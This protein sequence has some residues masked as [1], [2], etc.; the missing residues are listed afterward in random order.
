M[1]ISNKFNKTI[2]AGLLI[3]ATS[4]TSIACTTANFDNMKDNLR[5]TAED[6]ATGKITNIVDQGFGAAERLGTSLINGKVLGLECEDETATTSGT[7]GSA[8]GGKQNCKEPEESGQSS[9]DQQRASSE[10]AKAEIRVCLQQ[11]VAE[12]ETGKP[13]TAACK[14]VIQNNR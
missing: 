2:K 9:R 3:A 8:S 10:I 11:R 5:V 12:L 1:G 14:T 13:M 6:L 4:L 7:S